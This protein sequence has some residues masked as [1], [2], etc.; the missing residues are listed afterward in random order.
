[1]HL[2]GVTQLRGTMR[3]NGGVGFDF[4]RVSGIKFAVDECV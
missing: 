4:A 2:P 3:A 1:M